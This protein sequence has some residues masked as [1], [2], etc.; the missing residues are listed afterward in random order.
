MT[1]SKKIK[2]KKLPKLY[3]SNK[4]RYFIINGKRNYIDP[5]L[6]DDEKFAFIKSRK[7]ATPSQ[8]QV[9]VKPIIQKPEK[10]KSFKIK[11]PPLSQ[12]EKLSK[13]LEAQELRE[14]VSEKERLFQKSQRGKEAEELSKTLQLRDIAKIKEDLKEELEEYENTLKEVSDFDDKRINRILNNLI[15]GVRKD[16][17][18]VKLV[19]SKDQFNKISDN[20][21]RRIKEFSTA[22]DFIRS[23]ESRI[24]LD[25]EDKEIAALKV[26]L[27]DLLEELD[28]D[29]K[30]PLFI[31]SIKVRSKSGFK[32][33]IASLNNRKHKILKDLRK[34]ISTFSS[35]LLKNELIKGR[36]GK[37]DRVVIRR[38]M[39]R[40]KISDDVGEL[41]NTIRVLEDLKKQVSFKID[42]DDRLIY[43]AEENVPSQRIPPLV[44]ETEG[45]IPTVHV[46]LPLG[47]DGNETVDNDGLSNFDIDEI[48]SRYPEFMGTI[49]HD[50][51]HSHILPKI[52]PKSIGCF[53]IN[54]DTSGKP[55]THW[56]AMYFDATPHG[57]NEIDFYD[58]FGD[59]ASDMILQGTKSIS[60]K[61]M[62]NTYLKFKE[63]MIKKQHDKSTNCGFFCMKFLIDRLNGKPFI[64]ASGFDDH[65][66]GEKN[67]DSFKEQH[68]YGSFRYIP[69]FEN[70][71]LL[72]EGFIA[73]I[74]RFFRISGRASR[75]V[76]KFIK[77]NGEDIIKEI[78]VYRNPIDK[79]IENVLN[80]ASLGQLKKKANRLG[81]DKLYHL[82][83]IMKIKNKDGKI[84]YW[85]FE[86][87][88]QPDIK[89]VSGFPD[90]EHKNVP[91]TGNVMVRDFWKNG[92]NRVGERSFYSYHHI[93]NNCQVFLETLFS[94]SGWMNNELKEF[95]LQNIEELMKDRG[96]LNKFANIATDVG[97]FVE[98]IKD[99]VSG[100]VSDIKEKIGLAPSSNVSNE[101]PDEEEPLP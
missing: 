8:P 13:A 83:A 20:I 49:A 82:Y 94:A 25:V 34:K 44:W 51:I 19:K 6:T 17:L 87:T 50:Q 43:E 81:Y 90:N 62:A 70:E 15:T 66:K 33:V 59:E 67:I 86:K 23:K 74:G 14:K 64:H 53:I 39:E 99:K 97:G 77:R 7:S 36:Q 79:A 22:L 56:Q 88:S 91:V 3:T 31:K 78:K 55:G 24:K 98:G 48:M 47:G 93:H 57:D 1:K 68:G 45:N 63:N 61:L 9:Q 12:S 4:G 35:E 65:I 92:V 2:R 46:K 16:R 30:D 42:I 27:E 72:G 89:S 100:V 37:D 96:F 41:N 21:S 10:K 5:S 75:A 85:Q 69:S 95:I 76:K 18:T 58:S 32:K 40:A 60:D 11:T 84:S 38:F 73:D 52:T 101:L 28:I 29:E 54:T 80:T 71:K 26:E